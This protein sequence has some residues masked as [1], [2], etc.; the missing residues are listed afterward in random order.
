MN[1]DEQTI[2]TP[3]EQERA[4]RYYDHGWSFQEVT[5]S[6][7][8]ARTEQI[9][10][11]MLREV[12]AYIAKQYNKQSYPAEF[13]GKVEEKMKMNEMAGIKAIGE[14]EKEITKA[15]AY[16]HNQKG[17]RTILSLAKEEPIDG[18][19]LC[20]LCFEYDLYRGE[21]PEQHY[22][23]LSLYEFFRKID[24]EGY[25]DLFSHVWK[26]ELEEHRKKEQK[27]AAYREPVNPLG[28]RPGG[29]EPGT[30]KPRSNIF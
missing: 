27:E 5:D 6:I 8:Y 30:V 9:R 7:L 23:G 3:I 29:K 24:D 16:S 25:T 20:Q 1:E 18:V 19:S 28:A 4:I 11:D 10:R 13:Y 26:E 17:L 15:K 21:S 2:L 14:R 22:E 12:G